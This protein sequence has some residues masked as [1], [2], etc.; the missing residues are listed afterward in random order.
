MRALLLEGSPQNRDTYEHM[1]KDLGFE[2]IQIAENFSEAFRSIEVKHE[3][4]DLIVLDQ[5]YWG[6]DEL[7]LK[8]C[9]LIRSNEEYEHTAIVMLS[10]QCDSDAIEAA[11]RS[12]VDEFIPKYVHPLELKRLAWNAVFERRYAA[13]AL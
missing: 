5:S 3:P 6:D 10:N 7:C 4:F 11:F 13:R 2:D 12:G 9:R 1:F 8:L